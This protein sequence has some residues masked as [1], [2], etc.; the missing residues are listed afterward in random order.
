MSA[1]QR[2]VVPAAAG[3]R[4][5]LWRG[6]LCAAA[7]V[8]GAGAPGPTSAP[9]A[10]GPGPYIATLEPG[11]AAPAHAAGIHPE[12]RYEAAL[13]GLAVKLDARQLAMLRRDPSVRSIEPDQTV[14]ATDTQVFPTG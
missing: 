13:N 14:S 9:A 4:R 11:R 7:A 8:A 10:A 5:R 2:P 3:V 12:Y 6:S 1:R